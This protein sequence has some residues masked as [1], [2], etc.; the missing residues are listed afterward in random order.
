MP[1]LMLL[2]NDRGALPTRFGQGSSADKPRHF[3]PASWGLNFESSPQLAHQHFPTTKWL[4]AD[5]GPPNSLKSPCTCESKNGASV[6]LKLLKRLE[7]LRTWKTGLA[8]GL[9]RAGTSNAH[10]Q[11][12]EPGCCWYHCNQWVF[13]VTLNHGTAVSAESKLNSVT[14]VSNQDTKVFSWVCWA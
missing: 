1:N 7:G 11:S 14:S 12:S 10:G 2:G 4:C 5:R 9:Q 8:H 13:R 6:L 3:A